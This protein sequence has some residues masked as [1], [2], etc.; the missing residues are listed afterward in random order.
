MRATGAVHRKQGGIVAARFGDGKSVIAAHTCNTVAAL[1]REPNGQ[2]VVGARPIAGE[3]HRFPNQISILVG[4][5]L[6]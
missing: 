1:V 3:Y 6:S 5:Y 2:G 4:F